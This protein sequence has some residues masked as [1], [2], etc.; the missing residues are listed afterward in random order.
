M[1]AGEARAKMA[2]LGERVR[3]LTKGGCVMIV[4]SMLIMDAEAEER[5]TAANNAVL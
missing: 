5:A 3:S 4:E 1:N 2:G